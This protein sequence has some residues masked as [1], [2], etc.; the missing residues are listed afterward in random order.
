MTK[1]DKDKRLSMKQ[2]IELQKQKNIIYDE[3]IK[4]LVKLKC[5]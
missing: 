3:A 1:Q 2:K 5:L 4:Q